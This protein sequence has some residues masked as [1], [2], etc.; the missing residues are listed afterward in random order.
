M[1]LRL[2][3]NITGCHDNEHMPG[4]QL[5]KDPARGD[6]VHGEEK[7]ESF[8]SL[9]RRVVL[10]A[11]DKAQGVLRIRYFN[12]HDPW[13]GGSLQCTVTLSSQVTSI[14]ICLQG[15]NYV[16]FLFCVGPMPA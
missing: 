15:C 8:H 7:L 11:L 13:D 3:H 6:H 12:Y 5:V 1:T 9:E 4:T 16:S 2:A 10:F 14:M